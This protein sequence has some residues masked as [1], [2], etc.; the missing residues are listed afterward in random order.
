MPS[1]VLRVEVLWENRILDVEGGHQR[2]KRHFLKAHKGFDAS[3]HFNTNEGCIF[4]P[5]TGGWNMVEPVLISQG[6]CLQAPRREVHA[7]LG[8]WGST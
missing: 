7:E 3:E 2:K 4:C 6:R 5:A 1:S 8:G